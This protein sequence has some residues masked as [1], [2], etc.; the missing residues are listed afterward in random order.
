MGVYS[1]ENINLQKNILISLINGSTQEKIHPHAK[2]FQRAGGYRIG[3]LQFSSI[4]KKQVDIKLFI[5]VHFKWVEI[6]LCC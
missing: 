5:H 1:L 3:F 2:P 6:I 4:W